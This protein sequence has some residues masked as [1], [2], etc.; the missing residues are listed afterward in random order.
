MS[1][2]IH[3]LKY[4]KK[5]KMF[6]RVSKLPTRWWWTKSRYLAAE[7]RTTRWNGA[8]DKVNTSVKLRWFEDISL[9]IWIIVYDI[10]YY[11]CLFFQSSVCINRAS[12]KFLRTL[13]V[14]WSKNG[15]MAKLSNLP[16]FSNLLSSV[17]FTLKL[18]KNTLQTLKACSNINFKWSPMIPTVTTQYQYLSVHG[19]AVVSVLSLEAHGR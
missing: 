16:Y 17:I 6:F 18:R 13:G 15:K 14:N 19:V 12:W 9:S 1:Q 11:K 8:G 10:S 5:G 4:T 3:D 7:Q 2:R